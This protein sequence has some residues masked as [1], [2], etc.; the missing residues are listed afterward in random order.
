MRTENDTEYKDTVPAKRSRNVKRKAALLHPAKLKRRR[1]EQDVELENVKKTQGD[2]RFDEEAAIW[3]AYIKEAERFDDDMIGGF[4]DTIDSVLVFAAL[5]AGVIATLVAQTSQTLEPDQAKITNQL[6]VEQVIPLLR[7]AG[8]ATAIGLVPLPSVGPDTPTHSDTDVATNALGYLSLAL[9]VGTAIVSVLVK[10]WLQLYLAPASRSNQDR[11]LTRHLR[12]ASLLKWRLPEVVGLLPL[13]LHFSL[14]VF[15]IGILVSVFDL[16]PS[17]GYMIIV[18]TI[19]VLAIYVATVFLTAFAVNSPYRI[20][21]LYRPIHTVLRLFEKGWFAIRRM[22]G[23][24][25]QRTAFRPSAETPS[26]RPTQINPIQHGERERMEIACGAIVWLNSTS[27]SGNVQRLVAEMITRLGPPPPQKHSSWEAWVRRHGESLKTLF[28]PALMNTVWTCITPSRTHTDPICD[29]STCSA[30]LDTL[31]NIHAV[32]PT[33]VDYQG[34][35]RY[36]FQ[37]AEETG[38][39]SYME[40]LIRERRINV[41]EM[42]G[43]V[44]SSVSRTRQNEPNQTRDSSRRLSIN[45]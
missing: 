17:V 41:A 35:L 23:M 7:A 30:I 4:Q 31:Q 9:A 37:K 42:G 13:L 20:P 24:G 2:A 38:S 3:N 26:L 8:N 28:T 10:Q 43:G 6:L 18:V 40:Y 12:Y 32:D 5:S 22:L 39:S 11:A 19:G 15:A 16:D 44:G 27:T 33:L 25:R 14:G 36:A 45:K 29:Y 21:I 34:G 1:D